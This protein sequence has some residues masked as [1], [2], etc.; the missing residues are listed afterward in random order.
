MS[1]VLN[2]RWTL[3]DDIGAFVDPDERWTLVDMRHPVSDP[4]YY[5]D[6]DDFVN[7]Q[8]IVDD[9]PTVY[10]CCNCEEMSA[11]SAGWNDVDACDFC[12]SRVCKQLVPNGIHVCDR[13]EGFV[14]ELMRRIKEVDCPACGYTNVPLELSPPRSHRCAGCF[15]VREITEPC[16]YCEYD[17]EIPF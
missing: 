2:D 10:P 3:A 11:M 12:G 7:G 9:D 17:N 5:P 6:C 8:V 15:R 1:N 4:N 14:L 16:P 13:C